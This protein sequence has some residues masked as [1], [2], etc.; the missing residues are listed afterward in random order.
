MA[1]T[2]ATKALNHLAD[3]SRAPGIGRDGQQVMAPSVPTAQECTK[4]AVPTVY[5][6]TAMAV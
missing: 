2:A 3:P 1:N 6:S 5:V 4:P